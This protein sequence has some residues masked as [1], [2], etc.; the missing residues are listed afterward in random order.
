MSDGYRDAARH[1][2]RAGGVLRYL[3]D[4]FDSRLVPHGCGTW[5]CVVDVRGPRPYGRRTDVAILRAVAPDT[6]ELDVVELVEPSHAHG[7][8]VVEVELFDDA[9]RA[10]ATAV[11]LFVS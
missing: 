2:G 6:R 7:D 9:M 11:S 8:T 4:V 1:N 5:F 3:I 10:V